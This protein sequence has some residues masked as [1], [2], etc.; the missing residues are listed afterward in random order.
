MD[1]YINI[2]KLVRDEIESTKF[3]TLEEFKNHFTAF[4]ND[5]INTDDFKSIFS[6]TEKQQFVLYLKLIE[7][8]F[9]DYINIFTNENY[10]FIYE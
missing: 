8:G 10:E 1:K 4:L 9:P 6:V 3:S 2:D 7:N 5:I